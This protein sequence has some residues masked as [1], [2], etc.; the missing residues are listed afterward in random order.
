L[1]L[2]T[3]EAAVT[4]LRL[5]ASMTRYWGSGGVRLTVSFLDNPPQA[6]RTRILSHMNAW[7]R[8]ANVAFIETHRDGNVRIARTE[9]DGYW[10]YLGTDIHEIPLDAPTM[11]LDSFTMQTP[12]S[13]FCRVVRHEAG[14]T[15]GFVHEH[16][17]RELVERID[18]QKAIEYFRRKYGW[19]ASMTEA[20]VL[21]PLEELSLLGTATTD[22]RSI[23]CYQLP[24]EITNDGLPIIGGTDID[25]DDFAFAGKLYPRP[26]APPAEAAARTT[27]GHSPVVFVA[28]TDPEL[29]ASVI[30]ATQRA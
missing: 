24:G 4:E 19:S 11:N 20:Q 7:N 27:N 14:H 21:T 22:A 6:L 23:M 12:E 17:R 30:A 16:V 15:L 2:D 13:E 1:L 28:T 5:A 9:G 18:R 29:I 10:S 3:K 26:K 25:P 8:T